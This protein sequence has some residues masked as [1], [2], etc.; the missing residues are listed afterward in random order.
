MEPEEVLNFW[1]EECKPSDWYKKDAALDKNIR[2]KFSS[3]YEAAVSGK[4]E[5]W[6]HEAQ[7]CLAFIIVLDQFSRNMFRNDKKAF[8]HDELAVLATKHALAKGFDKELEGMQKS[9]L[10]MPL[11]H[12][13]N[14][15]DQEEC[16]VLFREWGDD[17]K[18]NLEFAIK[19]RDIIREFGRF[20]HRN[21][22]LGREST[23][24]EAVFHKEHGGF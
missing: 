9:F 20:P 18:T 4:L 17:Y 21:E 12:S 10:I 7:S 2:V 13:E 6:K 1:F 3:Y 16:V 14:I 8:A 19:H 24:E 23:S 5:S 15:G 22:V 11:M